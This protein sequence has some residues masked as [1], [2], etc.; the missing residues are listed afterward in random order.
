M[1]GRESEPIR[2]QGTSLSDGPDG[3]GVVFGGA[4]Y[5]AGQA[6]WASAHDEHARRRQRDPLSAGH[7]LLWRALPKDFPPRTTVFEYLDLWEDGT[8]ARLHYA[9]FVAVREQAGKEASPTA[10]IIDS[11]SVKG[12]EKGAAD[13]PCGYD[14]GKK[15]KGKKRHI[16]VD[17][18]GLP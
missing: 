16:L 14:A 15:V 1:D 6:G 17:T 11:Q 4:A 12:A 2:A 8:L 7:R 10:A 3:R 5:P 13:R 9:L 18:L